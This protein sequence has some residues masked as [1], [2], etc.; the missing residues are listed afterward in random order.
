MIGCHAESPTAAAAAGHSLT[1]MLM[2][3]SCAAHL[4]GQC[5]EPR[6]LKL[7]LHSPQPLP[8]SLSRLRAAMHTELAMMA[9]ALAVPFLLPVKLPVQA[10]KS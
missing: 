10:V 5:H 2:E 7:S 1:Q 6:L 9:M 3:H 8:G 4:A